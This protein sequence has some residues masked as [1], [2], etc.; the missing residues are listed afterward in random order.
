MKYGNLIICQDE[1]NS[2]MKAIS[3]S[4]NSGDKSYRTSLD[5]LSVE[6]KSAK[7]VKNDDMP[8]D[9]IRFNSFVTIYTSFNV[10]RCYQIVVPEKSNVQQNKI[11]ILSPMGLALF[12][13]AKGD[14]IVWQFPSGTNEIEIIGVSQQQIQLKK[15]AL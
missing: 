15:E 4:T 2:L 9:V 14:H 10:E 7:I 8:Q 6:L 13:Y 5:K 1:Y 11:S 3:F 12:G